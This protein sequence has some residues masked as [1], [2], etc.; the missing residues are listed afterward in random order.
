VSPAHTHPAGRC[1]LAESHEA[2][3]AR[4]LSA[5]EQLRQSGSST[6]TLLR[7]VRDY[8][9]KCGEESGRWWQTLCHCSYRA[10]SAILQ[11]LE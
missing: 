6:V 3:A 8:I 5:T 1:L 9:P 10:K 7:H 11:E 2:A 4:Y